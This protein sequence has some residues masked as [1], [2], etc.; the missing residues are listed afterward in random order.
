VNPIDGV[1]FQPLFPILKS[2]SSNYPFMSI[3]NKYDKIADWW[4]AHH[5]GSSYGMA[6]VA[7]AISYCSGR[8]SALDVGCGS[9]GRITRK[10]L[11]NKFKVTGLDASAEMIRIAKAN[12]TDVSWILGDICTWETEKKFD[13]IIAWDSIFHLPLEMH[14]VVIPK[15]CGM[16]ADN[17]VLLYTFG[18]GYG[19][20]ESDW[21]D[22][23]FPYSTLGIDGNLRLL[24]DSGCT[25][26]HLELDQFPQPHV[27]V[28]AQKS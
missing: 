21:K 2:G 28:I 14:A 17:G 23:K 5:E 20:H 25:C 3:G 15:L 12:H 11:D 16:L 26:R 10:L 27:F 18:D 7:R 13:L 19:S 4:H 6:Q 1:I 8:V 24:M 22:D 9:G